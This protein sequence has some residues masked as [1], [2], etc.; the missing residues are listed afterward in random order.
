[1]GTNAFYA[2]SMLGK[3]AR[4]LRLL[5]YDTEY[6]RNTSDK[7]L[8][9]VGMAGERI[10]LTSDR[11]LFRSAV[12]KEI[13]AALIA[14]ADDHTLRLAKLAKRFHLRLDVDLESCRCPECNWQLRTTDKRELER[15]VPQSS[16]R[17]FEQFWK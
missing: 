2:D 6:F 5:G 7:E 9:E 13:E 17:M 1:M 14:V 4:W 15:N 16:L 11:Q 12:G 8:L 10:L 3:L